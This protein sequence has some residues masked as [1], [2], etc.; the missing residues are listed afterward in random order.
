MVTWMVPFLCRFTMDKTASQDK[1]LFIDYRLIIALRCS[2]HVTVI[3]FLLMAHHT[4][5]LHFFALALLPTCGS[6]MFWILMAA[7]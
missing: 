6:S 2:L 7:F 3:F 5:S 1:S 4:L